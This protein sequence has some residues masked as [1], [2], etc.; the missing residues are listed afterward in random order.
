VAGHLDQ[1]LGTSIHT[2]ILEVTPNAPHE[3]GLLHRNRLVPVAPA[4]VVNGSYDPF[5]T[6]SPSAAA[7]VPLAAVLPRGERLF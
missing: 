6:P 3:A 2:E 4:P 5:D 7:P 1:A